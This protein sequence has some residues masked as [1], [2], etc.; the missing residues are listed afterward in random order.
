MVDQQGRLGDVNLGPFIVVELMVI[1]MSVNATIGL[2][3]VLPYT[4]FIILHICFYASMY[5]LAH[6]LDSRRHIRISFIIFDCW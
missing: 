6:S 1:L 5:V 3:I 2:D 4:Q